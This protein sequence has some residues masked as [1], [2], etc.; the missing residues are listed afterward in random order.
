ME[1]SFR[2]LDPRDVR[3]DDYNFYLTGATIA[4]TK[5][6]SRMAFEHELT[7]G[8]FGLPH[9]D[10]KPAEVRQFDMDGKK[11]ISALQHKNDDTEWTY[12]ELSPVMEIKIL[13]VT[14]VLTPLGAEITLHDG[15]IRKVYY[16]Q[17]DANCRC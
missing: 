1:Y 15:S 9:I 4:N 6:R 17:I 3:G 13:D 8:H 11:V 2:S 5:D 7:V 10:G 12:E 16:P 14:P